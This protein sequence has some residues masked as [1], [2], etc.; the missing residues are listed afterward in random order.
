M[1]EK[2]LRALKQQGS[3]SE[4]GLSA[5]SAPAHLPRVSAAASHAQEQGAGDRVAAPCH[6]AQAGLPSP[7]TGA[8]QVWSHLHL[9]AWECSPQRSG[10]FKAS[11]SPCR[12]CRAF[13]RGARGYP[14]WLFCRAGNPKGRLL[15]HSLVIPDRA[16]FIPN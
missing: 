12:G 4:L 13:S 6:A 15:S 2:S 10:G 3:T 16:I 11:L 5:Q 9:G 14:P 7:S 8:L 1:E